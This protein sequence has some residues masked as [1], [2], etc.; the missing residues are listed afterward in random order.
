VGPATGLVG[1]LVRARVTTRLCPSHP[2]VESLSEHS[3]SRQFV[4]M[5]RSDI[6]YVRHASSSFFTIICPNPVGN[7]CWSSYTTACR[8]CKAVW[9]TMSLSSCQ[10]QWAGICSLSK[11]CHLAQ[12]REFERCLHPGEIERTLHPM[13]ELELVL[14]HV[15][16]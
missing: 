3:V 10:R 6:R 5:L 11:T 14:S 2:L 15:K 1:E 7:P 12:L 16:A 9:R 13:L 8:I 4:A